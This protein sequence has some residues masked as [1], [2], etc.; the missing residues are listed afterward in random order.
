MDEKEASLAGCHLVNREGV[1]NDVT[2][3]MIRHR[4]R[5]MQAIE[6]RRAKLQGITELFGGKRACELLGFVSQET[7]KSFISTCCPCLKISVQRVPVL[8]DYFLVFVNQ[9]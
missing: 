8:L 3:K 1:C 2:C 7:I 9:L 5:F 6:R 4:I